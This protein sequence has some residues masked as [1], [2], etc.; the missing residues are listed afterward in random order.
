MTVVRLSGGDLGSEQMLVRCN[1]SEASW[2]VEV[3]YCTGDEDGD[4]WESTQYQCA[5][6]RHRLSGLIEIGEVLA[7]AAVEVAPSEFS[8]ESS[9][10]DNWPVA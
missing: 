8:C 9:E 7:A 6:A 5:D 2:P 1:L 4:G 10:V 3:N